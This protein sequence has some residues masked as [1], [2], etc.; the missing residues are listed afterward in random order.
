MGSQ[1]TASVAGYQ[2]VERTVAGHLQIPSIPTVVSTT[3]PSVFRLAS[4]V[5]GHFKNGKVTKDSL[6]KRKLWRR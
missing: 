5:I 4:I 6:S 3:R 1:Q 2:A